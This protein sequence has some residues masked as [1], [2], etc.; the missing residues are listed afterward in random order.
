[1]NADADG[2]WEADEPLC[3]C[4]FYIS[5]LNITK[6]IKCWTTK[7]SQP[8]SK[9]SRC[10]MCTCIQNSMLLEDLED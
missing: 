7:S 5:Q 3:V 1:M 10:T 4:L 8:S 6:E 2:N 9:M